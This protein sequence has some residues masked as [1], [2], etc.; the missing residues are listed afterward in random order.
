MRMEADLSG[1]EM[2]DGGFGSRHDV[3]PIPIHESRAARLRFPS[4]SAAKSVLLAALGLTTLVFLAAWVRAGIRAASRPRPTG[5]LT[6]I[7]FVTNFFDTLGIGS[8]APTTSIF[9]LKRLVPDEL[10][11]GTLNVGHALPTIAEAFVFIAIVEVEPLTLAGMIAASVAGAWLG[12]GVVRGLA[13]PAGADRDG[14]RAARGG[15]LLRHDEPRALPGRGRDAGPPLAA[16]VARPR[17]Q[18]RAGRAHDARAS[19]STRRA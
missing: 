3:P 8:F 5:L 18:L 9:K 7:G 10:I 1:S 6:L 15:G 11:P 13:A 12:A 2:G 4:L 17:R 16:P 14:P 19:A